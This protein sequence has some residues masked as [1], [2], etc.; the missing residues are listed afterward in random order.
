[1]AL[2]AVTILRFYTMY[3]PLRMFTAIGGVL[4]GGGVVLGLRFLYFFW[5]G[6]GAAGHVQSLILAAILTIVGFQTCMIGLIADLVSWNRKMLE[7]TLYRVRK[8]ELEASRS[9][10]S[11]SNGFHSVQ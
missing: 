3:R 7:E 9:G 11:G 1:M 6:G 8:T 2:S 5:L 10:S 4:I